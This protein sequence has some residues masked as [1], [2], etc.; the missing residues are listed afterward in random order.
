MAWEL[1]TDGRS[2]NRIEEQ[3]AQVQGGKTK[4]R[5]RRGCRG[6]TLEDDEGLAPCGVRHLGF[7]L[8]EEDQHMSDFYPAMTRPSARGAAA[9]P[10]ACLNTAFSLAGL[11]PQ[12]R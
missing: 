12:G 3:L 4:R 10:L 1:S 2:R 11:P 5:Y 7:G 8:S 9:Y 6:E